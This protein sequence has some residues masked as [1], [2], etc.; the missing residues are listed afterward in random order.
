VPEALVLLNADR[1]ILAANQAARHLLA[2]ADGISVERDRLR[3]GAPE[4]QRRLENALSDG[5]GNRARWVGALRVPRGSDG[6]DWLLQVFPLEDCADSEALYILSDDG[7]R[8][9]PHDLGSL[10]DLSP[11]QSRVA[12]AILEGSTAAEISVQLRITRNTLKTHIRRLFFK[13]GVS[14]QTEMVRLLS[15]VKPRRTRPK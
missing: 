8:P 15:R 12:L 3:I 9:A 2:A 14:R 10:F 7:E 5:T 1:E 6:P 13:I 11:M 4:L